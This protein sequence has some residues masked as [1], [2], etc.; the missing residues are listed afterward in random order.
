MLTRNGDD[1]A[2]EESMERIHGCDEDQNWDVEHRFPPTYRGTNGL[3]RR[4][5]SCAFLVHASEQEHY[6]DE[7]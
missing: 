1:S 3:A 2:K 4:Y 6:F 7:Q 5:A